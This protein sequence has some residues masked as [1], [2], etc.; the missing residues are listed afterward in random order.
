[1]H[2]RS[3]QFLDVLEATLLLAKDYNLQEYEANAAGTAMHAL[4]EQ[5]I[6]KKKLLDRLVTFWPY[7]HVALQTTFRTYGNR[8][9]SSRL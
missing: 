9:E 8:M 7:V 6:H 4:L 3:S 2:P 5:G 1:M